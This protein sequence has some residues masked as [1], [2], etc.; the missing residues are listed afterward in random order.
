MSRTRVAVAAVAGVLLALFGGRW[1]AVRYTEALWYADLGLGAQ[2]SRLIADRLLWQ[3]L[4]FLAATAWYGIQVTI[5]YLS[6]GS[7]HLPRR[8]GNLEIAEAVPRRVLRGIAALVAAALGLLTAITFHDLADFI[9]LFRAAVP[10]GLPEPVLG[11][12]ASF[13]LAHLPLI[14]TL[15][16]MA[17]IGV[18]VAILLAGGLYAL[19]GSLIVRR[20]NLAITPHARAHLVA[21]LA[22]LALVVAWGFQVDAYQLVG[23]GGSDAG[24]LTAVDRA[25]RIPASTALAAVGLVVAALTVLFLRWGNGGG[26]LA[27]WGVFGIAA[28][29]GRYVAPVVRQ[30]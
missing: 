6:I 10:F 28:I 18:V 15:H 11:R 22:A 14:E 20:R 25:L 23:G 9:T 17:T 7:V 16:L 5:V 3:G 2:F 24:A 13:Y 12:D 30:A 29:G 19:T 21:L 1:I 26:L 27:V 8:I 4:V